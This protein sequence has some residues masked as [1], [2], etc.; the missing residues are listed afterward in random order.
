[1][2]FETYENMAMKVLTLCKFH[3]IIIE[4]KLNLNPFSLIISD[5]NQTDFPLHITDYLPMWYHGSESMTNNA[6]QKIS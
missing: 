5:A 6:P 3:S 2:V 4:E 1:M